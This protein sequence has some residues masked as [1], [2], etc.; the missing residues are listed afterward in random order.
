MSAFPH[1]IDAIVAFAPH[2]SLLKLRATCRSLRDAAD[3]KMFAHVAVVDGMPTSRPDPCKRPT[4]EFPIENLRTASSPFHRLPML[5][6][7]D[8]RWVLNE[9]R[10]RQLRLFGTIDYYTRPKPGVPPLVALPDYIRF[11]TL[12]R[13]SPCGSQLVPQEDPR[14]TVDFMVLDWHRGVLQSLV[15]TKRHVV[16]VTWTSAWMA[17]QFPTLPQIFWWYINVEEVVIVF[18]EQS[19]LPLV[20]D[21]D[22]RTDSIEQTSLPS[23]DSLS[24]VNPVPMKF[25]HSMLLQ[26]YE[27][28]EGGGKLEI[29]GIESLPSSIVSLPTTTSREVTGN[30]G[31]SPDQ[32]VK[33]FREAFASEWF[34]R[35]PEFHGQTT[36]GSSGPLNIDSLEAFE[37]CVKFTSLSTWL[38]TAPHDEKIWPEGLGILDTGKDV[39]LPLLGT[40][41]STTSAGQQTAHRV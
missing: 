29:V 6:D 34:N 23:H 3:V 26:L 8:R 19:T 33:N 15:T 39:A 1:I 24:S 2:A 11:Q 21:T 5:F 13:H 31:Q 12:R 10:E 14:K 40:S 30:S 27:V 22:D 17:T 25:L 9:S 35:L 36:E 28:V 37:D 18:S 20:T 41:T 7:E 16:N 38:A 32:L 4:P